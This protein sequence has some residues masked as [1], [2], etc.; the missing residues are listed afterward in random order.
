LSFTRQGLQALSDWIS[1][2][3]KH[4]PSKQQIY[5]A[6][7]LSAAQRASAEQLLRAYWRREDYGCPATLDIKPLHGYLSRVVKD[8]FSPWRFEQ[9]LIRGCEDDAIAAADDRRRPRLVVPNRADFAPRRYDLIVPLRS[10]S[11][12]T[13]FIDDV[14]PIGLPGR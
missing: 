9:W 10:D 13:V 5:A 1:D 7:R 6:V 8:G 4:G 14:I 12:G 2:A 11:N 3:A